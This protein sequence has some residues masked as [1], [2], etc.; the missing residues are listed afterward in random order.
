MD[1]GARSGGRFPPE[2]RRDR[3]ETDR[4]DRPR[5]PHRPGHLSSTETNVLVIFGVIGRGTSRP[6]PRRRRVRPGGADPSAGRRAS[7][8]DA[9]ADRAGAIR[10]RVFARGD[11]PSRGA[12][13][14][15]GSPGGPPRGPPARELTAWP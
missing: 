6:V 7:R 1:G 9:A 3:R 14:V 11:A 5:A 8:G 2:T 15:R 4:E 10:R 12:G 13:V